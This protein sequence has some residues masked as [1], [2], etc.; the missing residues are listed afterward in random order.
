MVGDGK[1]ILRP[2]P[3]EYLMYISFMITPPRPLLYGKIS[4]VGSIFY[5][6]KFA[7]IFEQMACYQKR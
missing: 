6:K 2:C 3:C 1:E 4:G 5:E 7:H